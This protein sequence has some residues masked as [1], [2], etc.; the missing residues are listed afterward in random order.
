MEY[1]SRNHWKGLIQYHII[2]V[3]K[4]RRKIFSNSEISEYCKS[5]IEHTSKKYDFD[6]ITQEID[7]VKPDHW[8]GLIS[9]TNPTIA[10]YQIVSILK[11]HSTYY[12]WKNYESYLKTFYWKKHT[13]W[14]N[15]YFCS[16]IGNASNEI[17]RKYIDEQG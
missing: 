2:F 4:Y 6:I 1:I 5:I 8:H 9:L 3:C 16:S 7:H 14:T 11:Q 17:I 10:P 12:L 15:G 13:L